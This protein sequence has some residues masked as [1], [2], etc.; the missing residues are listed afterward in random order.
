MRECLLNL[1]QKYE[2]SFAK[3]LKWKTEGLGLQKELLDHRLLS[4]FPQNVFT[5]LRIMSLI[6]SWLSLGPKTLFYG[7]RIALHGIGLFTLIFS[8]LF[9]YFNTYSNGI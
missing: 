5:C 4:K 6:L 9:M 7:L 1:S 2:V 3:S 8:F